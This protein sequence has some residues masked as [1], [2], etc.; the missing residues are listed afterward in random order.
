MHYPIIDTDKEPNQLSQ[1]ISSVNNYDS[2]SESQSQSNLILIKNYIEKLLNNPNPIDVIIASSLSLKEKLCL[3]GNLL[4]CYKIHFANVDTGISSKTIS[5]LLENKQENL[6][7]KKLFSKIIHFWNETYHSTTK[8]TSIFTY[9]HL[10]NLVIQAW[11]DL[12]I[13]FSNNFRKEIILIGLGGKLGEFTDSKLVQINPTRG[14]LGEFTD[15]KFV[16]INPTRGIHI[17]QNIIN[18]IKADI[19]VWLVNIGK[20][21]CVTEM[22]EWLF[23]LDTTGELTNIKVAYETNMKLSAESVKAFQKQYN[24]TKEEFVLQQDKAKKNGL[25]KFIRGGNECKFGTTCKFYHG[26]LQETEGIQECFNGTNC[27][28]IANGKCKFVHKPTK[29]Q[30]ADA[31]KFYQELEKDDTGYLVPY[32]RMKNIDLHCSCDPFIILKKNGIVGNKIHYSIPSCSYISTCETSLDRNEY[33]CDFYCNKPVKFMTKNN[34]TMNFYCSYEH[35]TKSEKNILSYAVKQNILDQ[36]L[37][38]DSKCNFH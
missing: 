15:S 26:K 5:I 1:K 3:V 17:P 22:I 16:Q 33:D 34:Q 13:V 10:Y 12:P 25:C 6:E 19:H 35:M 38:V 36:I 28:H 24:M 30:L 32:S 31:K 23:Q 27:N 21:K 8:N 29:K 37:E 11:T 9:N 7:F 14:N 18:C 20:N 2:Q 4:D